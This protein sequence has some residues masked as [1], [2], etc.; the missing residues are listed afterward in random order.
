MSLMFARQAIL[1]ILRLC[2]WQIVPFSYIL[3]AEDRA[4]QPQW[5]RRA[6]REQLGVDPIRTPRRPL[7]LHLMPPELAHALAAPE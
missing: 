2:V 3:C 4:I 6:A 1:E 5:Y 7:P